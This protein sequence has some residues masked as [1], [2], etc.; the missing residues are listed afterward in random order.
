[1]EN[2]ELNEFQDLTDEQQEEPCGGCNVYQRLIGYSDFAFGSH[3]AARDFLTKR[4]VV[5]SQ[6]VFTSAIWAVTGGNGGVSVQ[7][8]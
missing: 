7:G 6:K 5:A 2:Q 1:M 4:V 8:S 3:G